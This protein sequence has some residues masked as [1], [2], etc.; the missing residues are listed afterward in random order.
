[1]TADLVRLNWFDPEKTENFRKTDM[2]KTIVPKPLKD[3]Y[4]NWHF[5]PA[6]VANGMI[7][8]SGIIGTS[9]DGASPGEEALKGAS[10]TLKEADEAPIAA[11]QAVRDPEAQF[12]TAFEALGAI[13][14]E[15]GASLKDLVEITTYHVD[16]SQHMES[17]MRV[18][19][20][21]ILEPYPAWTAIGVSELIV[22]GGL[23]EIRAIAMAPD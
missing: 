1:M 13:L 20:R 9:P 8:C 5:A 14:K 21:Y 4:E 15:A 16:I 10:A 17:F 2:R 18:K 6:V 3:V 23:M 7:Y 22:P 12:A 19:D 11:L